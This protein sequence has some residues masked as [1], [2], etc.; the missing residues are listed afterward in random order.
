MPVSVPTAGSTA[1]VFREEDMQSPVRLEIAGGEAVLFSARAPD[2]TGPNEDAA[3]VV[4]WGQAGGVLVVADG[5]GGM[6][7][8][9]EASRL[10]VE[11]LAG[12]LER[13]AAEAEPL[14]DAT[15]DGIEQANREVTALGIGAATTI[16]VLL[17]E[18]ERV[19]AIHVGDSVLLVA[20]QRGRVKHQSVPHGPVGYAVEA[21]LLD[22][23]EAL[24]HEERH[25]VSNVVGAADMRIE[26]GPRLALAARDTVL[27][28]SD[29][30]SDNLR[31]DEIVGTVR[32]GGLED[33]ARRLALQAHQRMVGGEAPSHAD[34]LTFILF[35]RR[36]KPRA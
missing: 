24:R 21:G 7:S 4:P 8:G 15:L 11:T 3:L 16:A 29:G 25:I 2:K 5:A 26:L 31:V 10:A 28:A 32:C 27:V 30:L 19:Q 36:A 13:A 6:R 12:R 1:R 20:G 22:E 33:A 35:R 9:S 14:R 17:V 23:D 34:D 18:D